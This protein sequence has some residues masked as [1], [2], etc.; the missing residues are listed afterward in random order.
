MRAGYPPYGEGYSMPPTPYEMN[1]PHFSWW[2]SG[3]GRRI[4]P[5]A[6]GRMPPNPEAPMHPP[7]LPPGYEEFYAPRAA[8]PPYPPH[9][10]RYAMSARPSHDHQAPRSRFLI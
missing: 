4:S 3:P 5:S 2:G 9:D 10:S 6:D 1:W 7:E 8:Y